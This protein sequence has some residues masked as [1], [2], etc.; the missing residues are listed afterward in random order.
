MIDSCGF[1]PIPA[2]PH[3]ARDLWIPVAPNALRVALALE[4]L[5]ALVHR[6]VLHVLPQ[7]VL[8]APN[9]MG[10]E[11]MGIPGSILMEVLHHIFWPYFGGIS[12]EI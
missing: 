7:G 11:S 2:I 4:P 1:H 12:P 5:H 6:Q 8:R 9:K 3:V 10:G